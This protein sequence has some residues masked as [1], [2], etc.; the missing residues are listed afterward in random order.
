MSAKHKIKPLL[1]HLGSL[2]TYTLPSGKTQ[3]LGYLLALP[4]FGVYD[5]E[6]GKVDV[7]HEDA[8][9]H[10]NLLS[11][12]QIEGL[13]RCEVGQGGSFYLK[14]TPE[15]YQVN[16][17]TGVKVS[18]DCTVGRHVTFRVNSKEFSG[19]KRNNDDLLFFVR[20]K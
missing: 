4:P 9:T 17:F 19:Q 8:N 6:L 5:T 10:N 13:E 1:Q 18:S 16:T 20:T 3:C 11:A 15:G 2:I 12:A 14:L 7:S